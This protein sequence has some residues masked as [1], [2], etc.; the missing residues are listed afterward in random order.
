VLVNL[1]PHVIN[2]KIGQSGTIGIEPSGSVARVTSTTSLVGEVNGVPVYSNA[3][4]E[5]EGIPAPETGVTYIVSM[6][7]RERANRADVV[8]PGTGPN[9]GAVRENGQIVAVTRFIRS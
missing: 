1:T 8:S 9:D 2:V 7:V 6:V 4:G 5:V 3:W